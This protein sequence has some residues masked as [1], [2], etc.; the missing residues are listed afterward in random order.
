MPRELTAPWRAFFLDL[1]A[2][3]THKV[4]LRCLGGFVLASCYGLPR[5]TGDVDVLSVVPDDD[6]LMLVRSAGKGSPLH[7]RHRICLDLVT[8]ANYPDG[9]EDRL[10]EPFSGALRH[11]R[12]A[13]LDPYDLAL[14][15]L[16]RN[17]ARDRE[18]VFYLADVVPL[19]LAELERRYRDEMRPYLGV[20]DREDLTLR[21]WVEAIT[22]R[23]QVTGPG[24]KSTSAL[25]RPH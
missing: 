24:V 16:E 25:Y 20:P 19:D 10:T 11:L 23:R 6:A 22:E 12:L 8:V 17:A 3:L 18:D 14:T 7:A 13:V 1:D 21:L 5:P 15:K 2:L 4:V 9:Y